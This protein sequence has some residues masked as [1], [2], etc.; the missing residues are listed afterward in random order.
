MST[1]LCYC[2]T[3]VSD[4]SACSPSKERKKTQCFVVTVG[5]EFSTSFN[6][7]MLVL[8]ARNKLSQKLLRLT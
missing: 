7:I 4:C 1:T 6:A 3:K 8:M 5:F 2:F